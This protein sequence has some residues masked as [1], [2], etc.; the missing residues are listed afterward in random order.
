MKKVRVELLN[1]PYDIIIGSG[2]AEKIKAVVDKE[3]MPQKVAFII[4]SKINRIYK[5]MLDKLLAQIN[6]PII[7]IILTSNEK[8][9]SISA[10]E[11]IYSKLISN[12][13]GRDSLLVGIGGG[14]IGDVTGFAAASYTRG[15][16]FVLLPTTLLSCVDSSV[17][18]KTGI[19]FG[20]TKNIIGAFH[21]PDKVIIDTNFLRTL[22]ER[23]ITCG[24]G[25]MIKYAMI[26]DESYFNYLEKNLS[27]IYELETTVISNLIQKSV[28]YKAS[29][30]IADE[31]EQQLRKVLNLGHT[32]AHAF[33]V[34]QNHKIKHGE[35][36]IVGISCALE[37]SKS[38]NIIQSEIYNK[39]N[40]LILYYAG[41]IKLINMDVSRIIKIMK[42]D[43]KNRKGI[44]NFVLPVSVGEILLDVPAENRIVRKAIIN[45]TKPFN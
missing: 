31:K 35:A 39:M 1:N 34:E 5:E 4:D 20:Q 17:G 40:N 28:E 11:K 21:Q 30:V 42:N 36:V 45:G 25:E 15:I 38:L 9:K 8:G 32:F 41:K 6:T 44:I 24:I 43:K 2:S 13:F 37:L 33:E 22:Y 12:N 16:P 26:S 10:L 18:G 23:E 3:I 27:K 29:V 19:N 7:K 14:I